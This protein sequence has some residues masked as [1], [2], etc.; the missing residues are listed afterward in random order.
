MKESGKGEVAWNFKHDA[1]NGLGHVLVY[2]VMIPTDEVQLLGNSTT[3]RALL[4]G[5]LVHVLHGCRERNCAPI[6]KLIIEIGNEMERTL[7][8]TDTPPFQDALEVGYQKIRSI[9]FSM[10]T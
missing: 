6:S 9:P 4:P 5:M 3:L 1:H 7:M 10:N 8:E 2:L